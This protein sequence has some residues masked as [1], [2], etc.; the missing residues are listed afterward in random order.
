M[1][2][3][4]ILCDHAQAAE[5]KLFIS[6][7]GIIRSWVAPEPPHMIMVG[8]G[9]VV[10]VPYTATNQLHQFAVVMV[11]EDGEPVRPFTPDGAPEQPSVE[12]TMPFNLGRPPGIVPGEV[13]LWTAAVNIQL[14]LPSLGGYNFVIKIDDA[15]V[16]RLPLRVAAIPG[17][18]AQFPQ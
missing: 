12:L 7:G 11:D 10:Q 2:I 3:D 14:P 6:G 16:E 17:Q 18:G 15:E 8:I 5:G 1:E 4:A 9:A 13:Q